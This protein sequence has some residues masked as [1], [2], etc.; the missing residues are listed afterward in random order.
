MYTYCFVSG[1]STRT[2]RSASSRSYERKFTIASND[3]PSSA[4]VSA[5]SSVTSPVIRSTPSGSSRCLALLPRLSTATRMP[6][7]T[8]S[9]TQEALIVPVP[10]M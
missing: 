7:S 1:P 6:L 4:A 9:R 2:A 3:R 8:E 10:P 5:A